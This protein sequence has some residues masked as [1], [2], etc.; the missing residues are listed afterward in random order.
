MAKKTRAI[1]RF[2]DHAR[3]ADRKAA[4]KRPHTPQ[5]FGAFQLRTAF[6]DFLVEGGVLGL[7]A[8]RLGRNRIKGGETPSWA[9][10]LVEIDRLIHRL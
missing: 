4:L 5:G 1:D 3:F 7:R 8:P 10:D 9:G 2:A 6:G